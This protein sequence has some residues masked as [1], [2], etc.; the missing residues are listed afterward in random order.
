MAVKGVFSYWWFP[1]ISGLVWCGMLLGLLLEW[2]VNQHGRRYPTMNEDANIA[3]ISNVGADRLQ[4]L[5]IVGCVLTS[6]FLDLAFFSERWLRHN[7]RLV[8][9]VSL[10]EK[11]LSI[12]SMVFAIVGT[13]GLICLS[14]FKTGKYKVLHNLFLG[15][16]IGGY[17]ISAVFICSE[18]QRLGKKYREHRMLRLSFWVKLVFIIV[19]FA[20]IV[21]FGVLSRQKKRDPAAVLEWIISFIFT[22]YAVS[23]VI[24]LYPA[25]RTKSPDARYPKSYLVPSA[26]ATPNDVDSGN[27]SSSNI[28]PRDVEMAQNGPPPRDF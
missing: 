20:L 19:E 2:L 11:I 7:G 18:Y 26:S 10:G 27:G 24:D 22:F 23:F 28:Y 13:V 21:A 5:F 6:V 12:L 1:I 17:L 9:N 14:I 3:Y 4:P 16:F 15:L 8:P 25:V